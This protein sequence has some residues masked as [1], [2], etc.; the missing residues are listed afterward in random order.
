MQ[1]KLE[2]LV[3]FVYIFYLSHVCSVLW[4]I[5]NQLLISVAIIIFFVLRVHLLRLFLFIT[6]YVT[7]ASCATLL[8]VC[9]TLNAI[10]IYSKTTVLVFW[11]IFN[12]SEK[13]ND[14][15]TS[16]C[17]IE[18]LHSWCIYYNANSDKGPTGFNRVLP[19]K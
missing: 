7:R 10:N 18:K 12:T 16:I 14:I 2:E 3:R 11:A 8:L 4:V 17:F 5:I 15:S 9:E 13:E 19:W 1:Q 6:D